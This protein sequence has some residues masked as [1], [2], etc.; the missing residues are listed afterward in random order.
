MGRTKLF[1][2]LGRFRAPGLVACL[3]GVT[4]LAGCGRKDG[5][6]DSTGPVFAAWESAEVA[7]ATV[8]AP[9]SKEAFRA[10]LVR[11]LSLG[12]MVARH[13]GMAE[14]AVA[15]PTD[16]LEAAMDVVMDME[17]AFRDLD[18][19]ILLLLRWVESEP[20]SAVQWMARQP[21]TDRFVLVIENVFFNWTLNDP[22]KALALAQVHG[23][24]GFRY[25]AVTSSISALG[26]IDP[27]AARLQTGRL[28]A[29]LQKAPR[30]DPIALITR[31]DP[32]A[33]WRQIQQDWAGGNKDFRSWQSFFD[34]LAETDPRRAVALLSELPDEGLANMAAIAAYGSWAN[35]DPWAALEAAGRISDQ[36]RVYAVVMQVIETASKTDPQR[37][38]D[39]AS[40]IED[41]GQR[42]QAILRAVRSLDAV[43]PASA[44]AAI[45]GLTD[46]ISRQAAYEQFLP[47]MAA[48]D[49]DGTIAWIQ[50]NLDGQ[51]QARTLV[52]VLA[53]ESTRDPESA[54]RRID[55]VPPGQYRTNAIGQ[56]VRVWAEKDPLGAFRWASGLDSESDRNQALSSL[57]PVMTRKDVDQAM[58]LASEMPPG[59]S[60]DMFEHQVAMQLALEDPETALDW[61]NRI[62]TPNTRRQATGNVLYQWAQQDP[63]SA[64][65]HAMAEADPEARDNYVSRVASAWANQD[66][67]AAVETLAAFSDRGI[68]PHL[69]SGALSQWIHSDEA[70]ASDWLKSEAPP[71]VKDQGLAMLVGTRLQHN[72][73][74]AVADALQIGSE[75]QRRQALRQILAW[76]Q[77]FD[78]AFGQSLLQDGSRLPAA[79]RADLQREFG[80]RLGGG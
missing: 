77:H 25:V 60:R 23:D 5:E 62:V 64:F 57:A 74:A 42:R 19:P 9:F 55:Q 41:P 21:Q 75:A 53:N 54:A 10:E 6:V 16:S 35:K 27:E 24:R 36:G 15:V 1:L 80:D 49:P 37:G 22:E 17:V 11:V 2:S 40:S 33:A 63:Q 3:L 51:V 44:L 30:M 26:R 13:A 48:S 34:V 28:A 58:V 32:D 66:P 14:A 7:S 67:E 71:G 79:D 39:M 76:S 4:V 73:P 56:V 78:P 20:G 12:S 69:F 72:A 18:L 65:L 46:V 68:E 70:R 50:S 47:T 45:A 61:T 31:R 29:L 43:D 38:L 52:A 59:Q 8:Q